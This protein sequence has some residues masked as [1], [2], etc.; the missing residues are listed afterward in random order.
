MDEVLLSVISFLTTNYTN[1][2]QISR[3]NYYDFKNFEILICQW[4]ES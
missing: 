1:L 3:K 2:T 4:Q